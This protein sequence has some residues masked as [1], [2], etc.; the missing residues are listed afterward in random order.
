[1]RRLS[2]LKPTGTCT[3]ATAT[4][5]KRT[6]HT[7]TAAGKLDST[8]EKGFT[9][10]ETGAVVAYNY[11]TDY[12][13]DSLG[14]LVQV[15]G[16]RTNTNYDVIDLSYWTALDAQSAG[17][18]ANTGQ[19]QEVKR[20]LDASNYLSTT[21]DIY[22]QWGQPLQMSGPDGMRTCTPRDSSTGRT[23]GGWVLDPAD[24]DCGSTYTTNSQHVE[25]YEYDSDRRLIEYDRLNVATQTYDYDLIGRIAK[26]WLNGERQEFVRSEE[27]SVHAPRFFGAQ[28]IDTRIRA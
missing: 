22:D 25:T 4:D 20:H 2:E 13:Y 3:A 23:N 26:V 28:G 16:P 21:F 17:H 14:R 5:C 24:P 15:N 12:D 10:D 7:Y 1:V 18:P 27:V 19:V 8:N 9:L 11:T 6:I